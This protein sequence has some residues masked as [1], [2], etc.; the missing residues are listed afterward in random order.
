VGTGHRALFDA[1]FIARANA[2]PNNDIWF[3]THDEL[4]AAHVVTALR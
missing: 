4:R 1:E 3:P 2:V